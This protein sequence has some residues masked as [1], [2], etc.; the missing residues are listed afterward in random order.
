MYSNAGNAIWAAGTDALGTP[1]FP[2]ATFTVTPNGL[3]PKVLVVDDGTRVTI[4][5]RDPDQADTI[6]CAPGG[7]DISDDPHPTH[8]DNPE[9]G[10]G[11]LTLEPVAPDAEPGHARRLRR[12]RPLPRFA[13]ERFRAASSSAC[14]RRAGLPPWLCQPDDIATPRC[15]PRRRSGHRGHA[16][17]RRLC[18]ARRHRR[19]VRRCASAT[20]RHVGPYQRDQ[21]C[22]RSPARDRHRAPACSRTSCSA[23]FYDNPRSTPADQ[24]RA[25]AAV[26]MPRRGRPLPP[27]LDRAPRPGRPLRAH[28]ARRLRTPALPATSGTR[29]STSGSPRS[30]AIGSASGVTFELLSQHAGGRAAGASCGP[31]LRAGRLTRPAGV[32]SRP[33]SRSASPRA[34]W[35]GALPLRG[36]GS[37][38]W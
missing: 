22:L 31:A 20:L 23:L 4:V 17:G 35:P 19:P 15:Y 21:G 9:F 10:S 14:R 2:P 37:A 7:H 18:H 3:F 34:P 36:C 38:R 33:V 29:F 28:R 24:L 32:S 13:D 1:I 26:V 8:G 5:N 30:P 11:R 27:G 12:P 6:D 16:L 25:D